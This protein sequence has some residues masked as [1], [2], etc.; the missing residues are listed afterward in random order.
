MMDESEVA[1]LSR[2]RGRGNSPLSTD[3]IYLSLTS[4]KALRPLNSLR[5]CLRNNLNDT[6]AI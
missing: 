5:N 4:D 3:A 2:P 6:R 1:P